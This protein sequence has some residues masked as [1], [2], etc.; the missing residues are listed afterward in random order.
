MIIDF[1]D[2]AIEWTSAS[3]LPRL[4]TEFIPEHAAAYLEPGKIAWDL[5]CG[6]GCIGLAIKKHF[7]LEVVLSDISP[8]C[9]ELTRK[10]ARRNHLDVE[11]LCGDLLEPF[12]GRKADYI[13][14]NPPYVREDEYAHLEP[15]VKDCEPKRAL[16]SGPTGLEFYQRLKD[17]LPPYLNQKAKL[18]FEIGTGQGPDIQSIFGGGLVKKDLSGHDRYFILET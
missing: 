3:I 12:E 10:N 4:E 5:C 15:S 6:T 16:V 2:V 18:F 7:S 8:E 9:A 14:C 1:F 17:E 13:F 11:V